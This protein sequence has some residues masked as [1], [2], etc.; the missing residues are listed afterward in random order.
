MILAGAKMTFAGAKMAGAKIC[1]AKMIFAGA[2]I[3]G[4]KICGAKM[5]FVFFC[6]SFHH[7]P[8]AKIFGAMLHN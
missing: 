8:G 1:G 7:R 4:A 6:R 5:I 2:K 3:C